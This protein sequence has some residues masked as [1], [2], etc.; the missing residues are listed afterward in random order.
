MKMQTGGALLMI[1]RNEIWDPEILDLLKFVMEDM[2]CFS[3]F[4]RKRK[5]RRT[6]WNIFEQNCI[7]SK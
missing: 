7:V 6:G 4:K 3:I 5:E 1:Y 2:N